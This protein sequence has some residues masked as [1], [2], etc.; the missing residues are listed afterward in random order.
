MD[1]EIQQDAQVGSSP[2]PENDANQ[3]ESQGADSSS[4]DTTQTS[5]SQQQDA[6]NG[7]DTTGNLPPKDNLYGEF[8]RKI[9]DEVGPII[10]GAVRESML[11][12]QSQN[13]AGPAQTNEVKYQGKYGKADLENI[14]RHPD[15]TESDKLF[16]TRGL[17]Y[18]DAK[19]D[20]MKEIDGRSEKQ[21]TQNRQSQALQSIVND[22]PQ[23][24]NRQANQWNFAD[25][26]WQK[27]M[28]IYNS[29]ARLQ[30]FGNEGLRV[31]IDRAYAQ[32]A[33]EGQLQIKK[34]EVKLTSQQRQLDKNQSQAL[35][36]GTLTPGRQQQTDKQSRAKL[37][38]AYKQ[39][40]GDSDIR[41][42][43][44]KHLIPQSWLT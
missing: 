31:A 40:P 33:R 5:S 25:P 6:N 13:V 43:A 11:G 28:Q 24:F 12:L 26:L 8:R 20:I 10:Q 9:L 2:T 16:A 14:L 41:T 30:S 21:A 44:L 22:Y 7:A 15:A 32:M 38:E 35:Q 4:V 36:S 29:E 42:A 37:L 39:N 3:P 23:V 17:S 34:K 19:E 18:I 1:N 27:A